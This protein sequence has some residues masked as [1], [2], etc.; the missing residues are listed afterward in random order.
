MEELFFGLAGL[1][2]STPSGKS[3]ENNAL[4]GEKKKGAGS[5]S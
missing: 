5:K 3:G 4:K 2:V 1:M